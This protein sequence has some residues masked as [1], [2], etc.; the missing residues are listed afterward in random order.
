MSRAESKGIS[1]ATLVKRSTSSSSENRRLSL[2][3]KKADHATL[4]ILHHVTTSVKYI[5][6]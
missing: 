4:S 3:K 5:Y 6:E 2:K 1:I